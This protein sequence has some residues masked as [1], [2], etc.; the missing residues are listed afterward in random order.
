MSAE[1]QPDYDLAVSVSLTSAELTVPSGFPLA[2]D[3][4]IEQRFLG[5]H[6]KNESAATVLCGYNAVTSRP[7]TSVDFAGSGTHSTTTK[8]GQ[9][10]LCHIVKHNCGSKAAIYDTDDPQ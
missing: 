3:C 10:I 2:G 7:V 5:I 1:L 9:I 4:A 8:M 6:G